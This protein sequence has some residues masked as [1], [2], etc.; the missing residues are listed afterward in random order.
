M[1]SELINVKSNIFFKEFKI[2][3]SFAPNAYI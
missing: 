3:D 1:T 2:D